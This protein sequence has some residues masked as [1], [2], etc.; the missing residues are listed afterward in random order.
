MIASG[1]L[2]AGDPLPSVREM[3]ALQDVPVA[4]LQHAL[5]VLAGEELVVVRQGRTAIVAGEAVVDRRP[6]LTPRGR[7]HDCKRAGCQPHVCKPMTAKTIR[8]IHSILSGAFATAKRWEWIAWNP[9]ESAKPPAVT[10][11]PVPATAPEDVAR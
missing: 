1:M 11:R 9:A 8:N 6:A 2:A 5:A 10:R 3:S 4:A 7:D